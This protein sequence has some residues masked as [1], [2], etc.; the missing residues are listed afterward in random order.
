[1]KKAVIGTLVAIGV[2]CSLFVVLL[3]VLAAEDDKYEK[4]D[5]MGWYD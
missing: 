1:M 4:Y 2:V 3:T 5:H